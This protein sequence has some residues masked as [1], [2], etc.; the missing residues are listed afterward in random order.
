MEVDVVNPPSYQRP[1][2]AASVVKFAG[3]G[4]TAWREGPIEAA[5]SAP[6]SPP[7]LEDAGPGRARFQ[8]GVWMKYSVGRCHESTVRR[9][10]FRF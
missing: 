1:I 4:I 8:P 9:R 7:A 10:P 3:N 2:V 6:S 5:V